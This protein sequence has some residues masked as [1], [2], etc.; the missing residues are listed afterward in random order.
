M[1]IKIPKAWP[2]FLIKCS[3]RATSLTLRIQA[4]DENE[5][6]TRAS[7]KVMKMFGGI[8]CLDIQ[9]MKRVDT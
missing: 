4:R 9:I 5:A 3:W 7:K 8:S 2:T 6:W 1:T